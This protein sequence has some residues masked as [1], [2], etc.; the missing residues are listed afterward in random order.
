MRLF[1]MILFVSFLIAMI[2]IYLLKSVKM[3][4]Q[5]SILLFM[6]CF[7]S[8]AGQLLIEGYRWQMILAYVGTAFI[9]K[10]L[11]GC[12]MERADAVY[13]VR[14]R[15]VILPIILL[16]LS[17]ALST[18]MPVITLPKPEG[19]FKVG[20]QTFYM[21][22]ERRD[23]TLTDESGD[24]RELMV[25][26]WYPAQAFDKPTQM[27]FPEDQAQFT[28]LMQT[29]SESMKIPGFFLDYFKYFRTNSYA[30]ASLYK[31][32]KPYPLIILNHG[33][34]TTRLIHASQ[35]ENLASNGYIVAAID[36]TYSTSGTVFP[37]GTVTEFITS[38][39]I[40]NMAVVSQEVGRIWAEDVI[41][42]IDQFERMHE[43][44][45]ESAF[46]GAIDLDKIGV[47]GHSFGGSTSYNALCMDTRIKAAINMDGSFFTL[48]GSAGTDKPFLFI[49]DDAYEERIQFIT[50][51][52]PSDEELK[53]EGL[54]REDYEKLTPMYKDEQS[55]LKE[56]AS[57]G[58]EIFIIPGMAHFNVTDLQLYSG[59]L[60]YTG[61]TG[62][63]DGRACAGLVNRYILDFFDEHLR[64]LT[65]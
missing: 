34:G 15:G 4:R 45:L 22:D 16:L 64:G 51:G 8:L 19:P 30:E 43:G 11:A 59:L 1:E 63:M 65:E 26:V 35:A 14:K 33:M 13:G 53:E 52:N 28:S 29:F 47:M 37:D 5:I 44:S 54:T 42:V 18:L 46:K 2:D 9:I 25:Q 24:K 41:F 49:T 21:K 3:R 62:S 36:H 6:L 7:L 60:K 61:M 23:E 12:M 17:F 50:K 55:I 39:N 48:A 32:S 20:T 31:A 10:K 56:A 58:S 40:S 57:H 27:L 38:V